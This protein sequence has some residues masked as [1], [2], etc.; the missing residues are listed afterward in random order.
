MKYLL[1]VM[2][3]LSMG[4]GKLI[5]VSN[6][7][8]EADIYDTNDIINIGLTE[9]SLWIYYYKR[10]DNPIRMRATKH[11]PAVV[12][13]QKTKAHKQLRFNSFD[14]AYKEYE[15]IVKEMNEQ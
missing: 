11:A 12:Y 9:S 4:F 2:L 13:Y 15:H 3:M 10:A 14:E 6:H 1:I 8:S 5:T 7:T